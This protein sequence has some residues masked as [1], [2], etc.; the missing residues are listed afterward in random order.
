MK[1]IL[2][3][4]IKLTIFSVILFSGPVF[5]SDKKDSLYTIEIDGKV[6]IP[7]QDDSKLYKIELLCHNDIIDSGLV[8]DDESFL[9][10]VKKDSWYTIRIIKEGY[11]PMIISIDTRLPGY[12]TTNHKFHFDTELIIADYEG[13]RDNDAVDFPIAIVSF[14]ANKGIFVPVKQYSK[15]IKNSLFETPVIKNG[16][17]EH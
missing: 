6:L 15:N 17:V 5:G 2:H 13:I 3:L 16:L 9:L 4:S 8:V 11:F 14:N 7:K 1:N 12:N 10:K